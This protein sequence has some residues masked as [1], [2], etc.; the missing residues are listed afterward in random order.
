MQQKI[1]GRNSGI[2]LIALI[3]TI[4]VLLILAGISITMLIGE[5]GL[6]TKAN[7]SKFVTE[8]STVKEGKDLYEIEQDIDK[9]SVNT[10]N[11]YSVLE[12]G[13]IENST[14][15]ST[16]EETIKIT[17]NITDITDEKV[18]LYKVDMD[19]IKLDI[20]DEYVIN[21]KTG[22]LYK[23]KGVKYQG[24][25]YHRPDW[26]VGKNG[27]VEEE[28]EDTSD[29]IYLKINQKKQLTTILKDAEVEWV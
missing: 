18:S 23:L 13:K 7:W 16:L 17:E 12:N 27:E 2:T 21:I 25:T 9:T 20:K 5:N 4:I 3:V 24:K 22:E 29:T 26:G 14:I 28:P 10:K 1:I 11:K 6:I 15:M 8:Y 19:L